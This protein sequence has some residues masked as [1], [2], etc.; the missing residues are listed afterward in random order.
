M[1][2]KDYSIPKKIDG[3]FGTVSSAFAESGPIFRE[4]FDISGEKVQHGVTAP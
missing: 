3:L 2:A 4:N 1:D